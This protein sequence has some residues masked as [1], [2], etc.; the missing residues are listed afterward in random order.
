MTELKLQ[1]GRVFRAKRPRN[2]GGLVNDRAIVYVGATQVQYDSPSVGFGRHYPWV[3][4]E[5]F[6]A[7]ADRDVTDDLPAGEFA[8]WPI[9]HSQEVGRR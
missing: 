7:W 2:A 9:K 6:L 1:R 4:K 5:K 3:S 8:E